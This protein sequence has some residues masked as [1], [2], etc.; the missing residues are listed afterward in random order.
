MKDQLFQYISEN[1]INIIF[2]T[3]SLCILHRK[4]NKTIDGIL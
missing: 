2:F 1:F 3:S 4:S